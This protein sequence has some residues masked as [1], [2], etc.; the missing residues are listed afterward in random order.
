VVRDHGGFIPV[1]EHTRAYGSDRVFAVGDAT[2][3]RLKHSA[4]A[5]AQANSAAETLAAEAGVDIAPTPWS[6]MLYGI[7]ADPPHFPGRPDSV[8]LDDGEPITH[9]LW[10]PP[11]HVTGRHLAPYV[12][13]RDPVVRTGLLWHPRGVPVAAQVAGPPP[14]EHPSSPSSSGEAIETDARSRQLL[15]ISQRERAGERVQHT[16]E[17]QGEAFERRKREV[18]ARLEA[19]GYLRHDPDHEDGRR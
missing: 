1:D 12:A 6:P 14:P 4:L 10:W 17:A 16:L 18:I 3:V 15:A 8:W 9:C 5:A 11:G 7:L 2:T 19:A 13:A